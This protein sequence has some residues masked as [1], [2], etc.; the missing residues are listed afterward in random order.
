MVDFTQSEQGRQGGEQLGG[1]HRPPARIWA[2]VALIIIGFAV[3]GIGT[4]AQQW[5]VVGA[6]AAAI[7]LGGILGWAFGIMGYTE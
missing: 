7:V 6:G 5:V 2:A 3:C 1:A 4:I